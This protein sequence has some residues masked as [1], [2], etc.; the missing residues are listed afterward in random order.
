MRWL[1]Y[2]VAMWSTVACGSSA[3][4]STVDASA[5]PDVVA[6]D[7][8]ASKDVAASDVAILDAAAADASGADG[9]VLVDTPAVADTPTVVD[10]AADQASLADVAGADVVPD[11][12]SSAD[13]GPTAVVQG[14]LVAAGYAFGECMSACKGVVEF[15]GA[16]L[17]LTISGW[18]AKVY[19]EA[20]GVLTTGAA[21]QL[22]TEESLLAGKSLALTFGCPDCADGGAFFLTFSD[23]TATSTHTYD[24]GKPPAELAAIDKIAAAAIAGLK[25]CQGDATVVVQ[26]PCPVPQP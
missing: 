13:V 6:S 4:S 11:I 18:D 24:Y 7:L 22:Q 12:E 10:V 5:T 19:S 9:P 20:K 16:S 23:G 25:A 3:A 21:A 8:V 14:H 2:V 15:Q 1:V 26:N 17:H